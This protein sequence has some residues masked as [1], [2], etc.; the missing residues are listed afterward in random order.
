M[1]CLG[2]R[3]HS[4]V[5]ATFNINHLECDNSIAICP[6]KEK[7]LISLLLLFEFVVVETCS[8]L[9]CSIVLKEV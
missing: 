1:L 6:P 2:R 8:Q 5:Y 3:S 4:F 7:M 9:D